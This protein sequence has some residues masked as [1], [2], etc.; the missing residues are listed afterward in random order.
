VTAAG[1]DNIVS[2]KEELK[3]ED[4]MYLDSQ[5]FCLAPVGTLVSDVV[6]QMRAEQATVCLVNRGQELA[7]IFTVRD[8]LRRVAPDPESWD[9]PI[10]TVMSP[11]PV[12]ICPDASVAEA[13]WL[14]DEKGIRDLPIVDAGGVI[15]GNMTYS[16]FLEYL[17]ARYPTEILNLPPRPDHF[18]DQVD[19]G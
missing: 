19:G 11:E 6:A 17:A 4:V 8:V 2:L 10:E 13:L 15:S 12:T 3:S 16:S 18:A 14:M 1:E 9:R 7:G 5:A